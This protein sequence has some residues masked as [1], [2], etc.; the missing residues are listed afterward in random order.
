MTNNSST[1]PL[2][3]CF[4]VLCESPLAK[5]NERFSLPSGVT[6][7]EELSLVRLLQN[8]AKL[9]FEIRRYPRHGP[10]QYFYAVARRPDKITPKDGTLILL[11]LTMTSALLG[12]MLCV[13]F[14]DWRAHVVT[15]TGVPMSLLQAYRA[16]AYAKMAYNTLKALS[17]IFLASFIWLYTFATSDAAKNLFEAAKFMLST[18]FDA[19]IETMKDKYTWLKAPFEDNVVILIVQPDL[20][21]AEQNPHCTPPIKYRAFGALSLSQ[22][23]KS[24]PDVAVGSKLRG[25]IL[26]FKA[27]NRNILNHI[28]NKY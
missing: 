8:D 1:S 23:Y 22:L 2:E 25:P 14:T 4:R 21:A 17:A 26:N 15:M 10:P 12:L 16:S 28:A 7:A 6:D 3:K 13:L 18:S 19:T 11:Y 20:D 5:I 24:Y 9:N 27:N